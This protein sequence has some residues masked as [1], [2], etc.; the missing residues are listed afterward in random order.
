[1]TADLHVFVDFKSAYDTAD[2]QALHLAMTELK[3]PLKLIRLVQ[4]TMKNTKCHVR[5]Q[6]VMEKTSSSNGNSTATLARSYKDS[7]K[8]L[9][10]H[11]SLVQTSPK[12]Y[13]RI[14][15]E[16]LV[17]TANMRIGLEAFLLRGCVE[18][19]AIASATKERSR[20]THR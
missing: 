5:I 10:Y 13:S 9:D 18:F 19:A 3:I 12:A 8:L 15:D 1:M 11:H 4:M 2:R 6:S 14:P 17:N 16:L 20:K 7:D